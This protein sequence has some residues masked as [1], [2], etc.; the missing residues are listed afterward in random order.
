MRREKWIKVR[1]LIKK[2]AE[3]VDLENSQDI[4]ITKTRKWSKLNTKGVAKRL[5]DKISRDQPFLHNPGDIFQDCG[6][7]TPKEFEFIKVVSKGG[8]WMPVEHYHNQGLQSLADLGV[9]SARS[10]KGHGG[11]PSKE[12][13]WQIL[14]ASMQ[15]PFCQC[16]ECPSWGVCGCFHLD[17]KRCP[18]EPQ[19]RDPALGEL[20]AKDPSWHG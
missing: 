11:C 7:M 13:R 14:A 17:L 3:F 12:Y 5:F 9:A 2:E 16:A 8:L 19:A 20:Q 18:A 10:S 15:C 4:H 6:R 1:V